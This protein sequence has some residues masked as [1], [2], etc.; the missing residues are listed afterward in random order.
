MPSEPTQKQ[1]ARKPCDKCGAVYQKKHLADHERSCKGLKWKCPH[2][3]LEVVRKRA[4]KCAQM[5][6]A[7]AQATPKELVVLK[8]RIEWQYILPEKFKHGIESLRGSIAEETRQ[9]WTERLPGLDPPLL[10]E[11]TQDYLVNILID[12]IVDSSRYTT[13]Q[14]GTKA[15][16]AGK[17]EQIKLAM[18]ALYEATNNTSTSKLYLINIFTNLTSNPPMRVRSARHVV[19]DDEFPVS[20]NATPAG[21]F[22]DLHH[23]KFI[24]MRLSSTSL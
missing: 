23:G 19:D 20:F 11:H 24:G 9:L 10:L 14:N 18:K 22:I 1:P 8:E 12:S 13:F 4:H 3:S 21:T 7:Q 5:K 17:K 2:C 16:L 15:E 6:A